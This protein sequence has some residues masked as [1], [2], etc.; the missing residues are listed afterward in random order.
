MASTG[1]FATLIADALQQLDNLQPK[2]P[3]HYRIDLIVQFV[4][5]GLLATQSIA[6]L[7]LF[8]VY[9]RKYKRDLWLIRL[10]RADGDNT[11]GARSIAINA[12]PFFVFTGL[13][14]VS[15]Q[16][17]S[18]VYNWNYFIVD[19]SNGPRTFQLATTFTP[20]YVVIIQA[21]TFSL[22]NLFATLTAQTRL[23]GVASRRRHAWIYNVAWIGYIVLMLATLIP[24]VILT[25]NA[26]NIVVIAAAKIRQPLQAALAAINAGQAFDIMS[27]TSAQALYVSLQPT[28]SMAVVYAKTAS[29]LCI[30]YVT[31]ILLINVYS[32]LLVL[33]LRRHVKQI[34]T[35]S[36]SSELHSGAQHTSLSIDAGV[37][38]SGIS[39]GSGPFRSTM[40]ERTTFSVTSRSDIALRRLTSDL[41]FAVPLTSTCILGLLVGLCAIVAFGTTTTSWSLSE[42]VSPASIVWSAVVNFDIPLIRLYKI[43]DGFT[44]IYTIVC[45]LVVATFNYNLV[46]AW[47]SENVVIRET[48]P[49]VSGQGTSAP[50]YQVGLP[51]V[52]QEKL[53]VIDEYKAQND[54]L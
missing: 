11:S 18:R 33:T 46:R 25:D 5:C 34:K 36:A 16:I 10:K 15:G 2:A 42:F 1:S 17:V 39:A 7:T 9:S 4:I 49:G 43:S 37:P 45:N 19:K 48:L 28:V 52:H 22:S 30:V 24:L 20:W 14:A 12:I 32:L 40:A 8:V 21:Y 13:I 3:A 53:V 38:Q 29:I 26:I 6:F 50:Q 44:F 35:I 47:R 31:V 51:T 54:D 23:K 41:T 27:L